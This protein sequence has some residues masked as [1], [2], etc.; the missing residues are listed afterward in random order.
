MQC[1]KFLLGTVNI[2]GIC[3]VL[4]GCRENLYNTY[5]V[6]IVRII[7]SQGCLFP[8]IFS[9]ETCLLS[10]FVNFSISL[11][12]FNV[13]K[14]LPPLDMKLD[15]VSKIIGGFTVVFVCYSELS[16][17]Y[18]EWTA[19]PSSWYLVNDKISWFIFCVNELF[20]DINRDAIQKLASRT[21][22]TDAFGYWRLSCFMFGT[23]YH[24]YI[25]LP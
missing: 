1:R 2:C 20:S 25:P 22:G 9:T 15:A 24:D 12:H 4:P 5:W 14:I 17:R 19:D 8:T 13:F 21:S 16:A 6:L 23:I 7:I 10:L 18:K 11:R 3:L